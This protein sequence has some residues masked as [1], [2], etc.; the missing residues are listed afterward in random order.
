MCRF[1]S[2]S[3]YNTLIYMGLLFCLCGDVLL[4]LQDKFI[5]GLASFLVAH[6]LFFSFFILKTETVEYYLV[7][8]IVITGITVYRILFKH[9]GKLKLPVLVYF[10]IILVMVFYGI[11]LYITSFSTASK[12]IALA[13]ILFGFSDANLAFDKFMKTYKI[14]EFLILSTYFLSIFLIALSLRY[15]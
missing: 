1:V 4:M 3:S 13:V 11:N 8:P 14:A 10:V 2:L 6:F 9:L 5:H 7:I 12:L 15:F